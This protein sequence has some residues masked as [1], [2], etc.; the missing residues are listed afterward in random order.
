[1]TPELM[2]AFSTEAIKLGALPYGSIARGAA[3]IGGKLERSATETAK[4][5]RDASHPKYVAKGL[6][7]GL[8]SMTNVSAAN[9]KALQEGIEAAA[10]KGRT[11]R[12]DFYTDPSWK[13]WAR[14]HGLLAN[15]AKYEGTDSLL[16]AKNVIG[17]SMPGQMANAPL[18][19]AGAYGAGKEK[20]DPR[21]GRK[22]GVGERLGRAGLGLSTGIVGMR[23][24]F[25]PAVIGEMTGEVAGGAAG[26]GAD[27][28]YRTAR[29]RGAAPAARGVS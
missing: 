11:Y 13:G 26:R 16:K 19:A 17:R 23:A 7:E 9:R 20:V 18:F 6:R 21:T 24:G 3:R 29:H 25:V 10:K 1:M 22:R 12:A 4:L 15:V 2:H 14:R 28:L 27:V 8:G 5:L